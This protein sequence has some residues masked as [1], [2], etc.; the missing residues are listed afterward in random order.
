MVSTEPFSVHIDVADDAQERNRGLMFR[1][2][3]ESNNGMLFVFEEPGNLSFWMKNTYIPLDMIFI[4]KDLRIVDIK[5]NVQPC[6]H[7]DPCPSYSSKE[8]AKYVIEV[9]AGFTKQ[10][11]IDI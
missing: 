2:S 7:E 6:I 5:E 3:L 1:K 8:P 4:D 11:K 10:N 9:Y